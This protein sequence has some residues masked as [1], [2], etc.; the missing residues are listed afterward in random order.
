MKEKQV[1]LGGFR[2]EDLMDT[3]DGRKN[4]GDMVPVELY[5][6]L[7]YSMRQ[8]IEEKFGKD[9]AIEIL[10][11][12]GRLAGEQFAKT[13]L[14]LDQDLN[15]FLASVQKA[16]LDL[17]IGILRVEDFNEESG[18]ATLT[19]SEDLDC[20]GLPVIGETVCNYDEGFI[21]GLF[22]V[23]TNKNY[24]AKEIDCWAKGDRVCRFKASVNE[25]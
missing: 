9:I 3:A 18:D 5:R 14:N 4:L 12:A 11:R 25:E 17:K 13:S 21:A 22:S 20:S 15:G 7:E 19:I 24:K 10:R 23:F 1:T 2:W 16:F 6:S 8:A